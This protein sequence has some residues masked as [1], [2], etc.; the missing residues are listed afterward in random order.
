[1]TR[2]INPVPQ[3]LD[4]NGDPLKAGKMF[5][6][7]T[8]TNTEKVT[9][10][11]SAQ[12]I[13]NSHPVILDA[14][15]RLPNVFFSG[16]AKQILQDIN[17]TQIFERD[18]VGGDTLTA[19]FSP[20]NFEVSY[21]KNDIVE[22]SDGV[23][24]KSQSNGNLNNDP[25]VPSE[26]WASIDFDYE[27]TTTELIASNIV[28]PT[29]KVILTTG[30]SLAGGSG[31]APWKQNGVTGQTP[32]KSPAQLGDGLLNDGNG[33]Q[34]AIVGQELIPEMLGALGGGADDLLPLRA[35]FSRLEF[36]KVTLNKIFSSS[37]K[38]DMESNFKVTGQG[39]V[40]SLGIPTDAEGETHYGLLMAT[41]KTNIHVDIFSVDTSS[42]TSVFDVAASVRGIVFR[43]CT[44]YSVYK[45]KFSTT[46]GGVAS[47]GGI[48]YWVIGTESTS[49]A[50]G[51]LADG[52]ID[53][54]SEFDIDAKNFVIVHNII[55]SDGTGRW[56]ILVNGVKSGAQEM[57]MS[58]FV[59]ESNI[60]DNL[61]LDGIWIGGRVPTAFD[62]N[63][64]DNII[65]NVRKGISLSGCKGGVV[66]SNEI[67]TTTDTGI[68][69]WQETV[70][71][72]GA[73]DLTVTNNNLTDVAS[74]VGTPSALWLAYG[75]GNTVTN[76][77]IKG[78]THYYGVTLAA[79]NVVNN[80]VHHNPTDKGRDSLVF[81]QF[82]TLNNVDDGEY[83]PVIVNGTNVTSSFAELSIYDASSEY[84]TVF[85]RVK[86]TPTAGGS[87][88]DLTISLPIASAFTL[89]TDAIGSGVAASTGVLASADVATDTIKLVFTST[90]TFEHLIMGSVRYKVRK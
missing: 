41:A 66:T 62:F 26:F 32:N 49:V 52:I 67:K 60:I 17:G 5:Y 63:V 12:T 7:D 53:N 11:D 65:T 54:W 3:F 14:A 35:L 18:P 16:V 82:G 81:R 13:E 83:T 72:I 36:T 58:N 79:T 50:P 30:F 69:L 15:G 76:N 38:I 68:E 74:A 1:M 55:N 28:F 21:N 37:K 40:K 33:N 61:A 34:W 77:R 22:G 51:N 19:D 25:I 4:G 31:S 57:S 48:N 84:I 71:E 56:G 80:T 9:Y 47:I 88:T 6:F 45:N 73:N 90:G 78:S 42:W 86:V 70:G 24:Y 44:N 64:S 85:F 20:W 87:S 27:L 8:N 75:S 46:G 59:I 39:G 2:S 43:R 10:K 89:A 23:F 29:S